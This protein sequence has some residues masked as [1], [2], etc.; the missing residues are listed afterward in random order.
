MKS[1]DGPH[2]SHDYAA[3]LVLEPEEDFPL[4]MG[5]PMNPRRHFE[6]ADEGGIFRVPKSCAGPW[7]PGSRGTDARA[8]SCNIAVDVYL[9]PAPEAP[10]RT[11]VL[12][13][14]SLPQ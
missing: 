12:P 4:T 8:P 11:R 7:S 1:P 10:G 6:T 14:R 5:R 3:T 13:G 9:S 2:H